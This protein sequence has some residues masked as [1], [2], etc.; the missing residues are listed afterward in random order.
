MSENYQDNDTMFFND[1]ENDIPDSL[2]PT[3]KKKINLPTES[4]N[5]NQYKSM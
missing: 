5:Y 1:P 4:F 3:Q 2:S